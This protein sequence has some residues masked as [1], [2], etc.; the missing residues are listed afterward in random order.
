MKGYFYKHLI[1][2]VSKKIFFF[3]DLDKDV[4]RSTLGGKGLAI[5]LCLRTPLQV[6]TS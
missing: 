5:H 1:I 2:D 3:E 4:V 6:L